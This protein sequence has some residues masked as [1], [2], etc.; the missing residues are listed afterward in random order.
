[1]EIGSM[2][3]EGARVDRFVTQFAPDEIFVSQPGHRSVPGDTRY[4][5]DMS[6]VGAWRSGESWDAAWVF[7]KVKQPG[8]PWKPLLLSEHPGDHEVL[9]GKP[10]VI[11]PAGNGAG[12]FI[13]LKGS[14][15][16]KILPSAVRWRVRLKTRKVIGS[17]EVQVIAL[18]MVHVP[19][20]QFWAGDPKT[21][22]TG[23]FHDA[24]KLDS[25]CESKD[26]EN[27]AFLVDSE[28]AIE[29]V[30]KPE[31]EKGKKRLIYHGAH[32]AR[33]RK[34]FPKGFKALYIMRSQLTQG[35]FADFINSLDPEQR[36]LRYPYVDGAFRF[37]I[38]WQR[39]GFRVATRP[40]RACNFL[41]WADGAAYAAW[42]GL[43][44]MSEFEYEKAC[45]GVEKKNE[46]PESGAYAWGDTTLFRAGVI[47]GAGGLGGEIQIAGNCNVDNLGREFFGG[48]G[49]CGPVTDDIFRA[50]G[51]KFTPIGQ[52]QLQREPVTYPSTITG[53]SA[54]G[55]MGLSGNLWELCVSVGTKKGRKFS[56][57]HGTGYLTD[58]GD[59]PRD[60]HWPAKKG[61]FGFRGGSWITLASEA[62]VADRS[63]ASG[64]GGRYQ[65][66]SPDT[67][68][69]CVRT[70][71]K[72]DR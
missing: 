35:Q 4:T 45:R 1:M 43:R 10:A 27:S 67:G 38:H 13:H 34:K 60:L 57:K 51:F 52:S 47:Q 61:G 16:K 33:I 25:K 29:V 55:V 21:T 71:P 40:R 72:K 64:L 7:L 39:Q 19:E 23:A 3:I 65:F 31:K 22:V 62:R 49:G 70:A 44:P 59:A 26:E 53:A 24:A 32:R 46:V 36:T 63:S 15:T 42:A 66:R 9:S 56:G 8:D 17:S 2:Q 14:G 50:S 58:G 12:V 5:F 30:D 6:W 41:S 54:T 20:G 48:D 37:A 69:R 28:D 68:C 18:R 11:A